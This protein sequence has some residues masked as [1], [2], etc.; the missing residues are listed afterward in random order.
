MVA[1]VSVYWEWGWKHLKSPFEAESYAKHPLNGLNWVPN[2][3]VVRFTSLLQLNCMG[4]FQEKLMFVLKH[5]VEELGGIIDRLVSL[6]PT[7]NE[8][9]TK[10]MKGE[11]KAVIIE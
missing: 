3:S 11:L 1:V 10:E 7:W 2:E 5:T 6:V 8:Y 9:R 4:S